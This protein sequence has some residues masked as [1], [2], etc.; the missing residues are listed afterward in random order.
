MKLLVDAGNSC[1]KW[2]WLGEDGLQGTGRLLH[3]KKTPKAVLEEAWEQLDNTPDEV[4]VANVAGDTFRRSLTAYCKKRW[5]LKADYLKS[6]AEQ[7]GVRNSYEN[8]ESLGVDRWLAMLG[9]RSMRGTA[10][11]VIDCGTALTIDAVDK[12]GRHM[13]G[14]ILPGMHLMRQSLVDAASGIK[15]RPNLSAA[16]PSTLL[17]SDTDNAIIVGTLY[18]AIAAIDRIVNDVRAELGNSLQ[19]YITGGEATLFLPLIDQRI[20][21]QPNLVFKGMQAVINDREKAEVL[22]KAL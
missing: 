10:C 2:A 16:R 12:Q 17:A 7:C 18:T 13:G 4:V 6:M 14:L 9:A 20:Q 11:C 8:P 5:S 19:C 21:H 1:L 15:E 3:G 22:E